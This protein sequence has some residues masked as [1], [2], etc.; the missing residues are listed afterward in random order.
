MEALVFKGNERQALTSSLLVAEKF[1]KRHADVL[2]AI[3]DLLS[4]LPENECKRNFAILETRQIPMPNGGVRDERVLAMTRDGFTLL[5]MGFTGE[6]ALKFK[7]DYIAAFNQMEK[8]LKDGKILSE[9]KEA[10]RMSENTLYNLRMKAVSWAAKL[11][12]LNEVS[13]L[14]MVK[15]V[16]DPLGLPSP[17]Y[18]N[19][20]GAIHSAT[21][22]LK[23]YGVK[24]ETRDFNQ[25]MFSAGLLEYKERPSKSKG[26][27]KFWALSESGLTYGE[28]QVSPKNPRETQPL[29][30][31]DK[32]IDLLNLLNLAGIS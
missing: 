30:Y 5:A 2:R 28:N 32:F 27:A 21:Y 8:A 7:L 22:L 25:K 9:Q 11:L 13:K 10:K 23:E 6:K 1:E 3:D 18:A 14:E 16:T 4:K 19:S 29:Y 24:I 15:A 17:G 31:D 12:N 20:E 26:T